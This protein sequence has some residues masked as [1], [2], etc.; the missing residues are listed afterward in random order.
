M[1]AFIFIIVFF[2]MQSQ[3]LA[4]IYG[5]GIAG[6]NNKC[7]DGTQGVLTDNFEFGCSWENATS[8]A[9]RAQVVWGAGQ[10]FSASSSQKYANGV[11]SA[12]VPYTGHYSV[13]QHFCPSTVVASCTRGSSTQSM[14]ST[15]SVNLLSSKLINDQNPKFGGFSG[16]L[17]SS[18]NAC[19]TF[20]DDSGEEWK[21][22]GEF[23]CADV[24]ALP[25]TPS[26]CY[27][28]VNLD[29]NVDMG[30]LERGKI[31][32]V[33]E[34]GALGNVKKTFP[35]LCTRDAGVSVK[36]TFQF[37]PLTVNG[38][39]VVSSSTANL[40]VAIFY[41][42]ELVGPASTPIT[43]NFDAGYT[44]RELEFQAVRSPDVELKNIPTGTFTAN[45]VMIMTEQ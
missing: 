33:P 9:D 39:E 11:E 44:N 2:I 28:N 4:A 23:F 38:N 7:V 34:S 25:E 36:T 26:T 32:T 31:A 12:Y 27:L 6:A 19:Y 41:N 13:I 10:K 15:G 17:G 8:G 3:S 22:N 20:M 29:M 40:G 30:S 16:V 21:A 1:K 45:A 14:T 18:S 37:T 5:I 42:G 43:E 24:G 35:V